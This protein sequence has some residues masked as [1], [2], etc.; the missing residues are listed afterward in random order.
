MADAAGN[1]APTARRLIKV[2]CPPRESYCIDPDN[3]QPAC[4][5]EG[6]CGRSVALAA[7]YGGHTSR[8]ATAAA[9]FAL[10]PSPPSI[11]LAG[12]AVVEIAAGSTYDR[13]AAGTAVGACDRGAAAY[14]DRDGHLDDLV[15][16]CGSRCA[17]WTAAAMLMGHV[18]QCATSK[19]LCVCQPRD[20]WGIAQSHHPIA[21]AALKSPRYPSFAGGAH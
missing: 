10:A 6:A 19:M 17:S 20:A 18:C 7:G 3:D 8:A 13:C 14:D 12:P 15:H 16:V 9:A 21:K 1:R 11:T 5:W 4:T 2:A